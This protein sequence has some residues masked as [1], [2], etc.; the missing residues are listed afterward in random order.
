MDIKDEEL[1]EKIRALKQANPYWGYR[2]ICEYLRNELG[3]SINKKR[4]YRLMKEN[5]L[6]L[7]SIPKSEISGT[8]YSYES[9]SKT[10]ALFKAIGFLFALGVILTL[11]FKNILNRKE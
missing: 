5:N 10:T 2:K 11:I 7:I 4:I 6:L 8:D 3:M 1:L 9:T